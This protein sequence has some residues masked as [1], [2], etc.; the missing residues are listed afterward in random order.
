ML[1]RA[2][3][4]DAIDLRPLVTTNARPSQRQKL[5]QLDPVGMNHPTP[6]ICD[7]I[8][9]AR[10]LVKRMIAQ[11]LEGM[12]RLR[13]PSTTYWNARELDGAFSPYTTK[14]EITTAKTK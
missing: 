13:S 4:E 10:A 9:A 7:R 1:L 5:T 3:N 8:T 11:T 6:R 14:I 2:R 12:S